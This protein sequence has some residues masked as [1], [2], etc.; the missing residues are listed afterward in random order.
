LTDLEK[1][2]KNLNILFKDI[3]EKACDA[4]EGK[5]NQVHILRPLDGK[6]IKIHRSILQSSSIED[7]NS[8]LER[9]DDKG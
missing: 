2:N 8:F 6:P 5:S 7:R 1:Q 4:E 3:V 9:I